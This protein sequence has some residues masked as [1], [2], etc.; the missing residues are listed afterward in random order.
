M[1]PKTL[2]DIQ[3]MVDEWCQAT[4]TIRAVKGCKTD[5]NTAMVLMQLPTATEVLS[6]VEWCGRKRKV[7]HGEHSLKMLAGTDLIHVFDISQTE[8]ISDV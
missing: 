7:K 3:S 8:K 4:G 6:F 5:F 1:H 2:T